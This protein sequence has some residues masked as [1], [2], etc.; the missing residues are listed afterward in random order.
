MKKKITTLFLTLA[1]VVS[2]G[3]FAMISLSDTAVNASADTENGVAT[4][5][6]VSP[7]ELYTFA[8]ATP[9]THNPETTKMSVAGWSSVLGMK[10]F[11]KGG[12]HTYAYIGFDEVDVTNYAFVNIKAM[13]W[14]DGGNTK[15]G[16]YFATDIYT[17]ERIDTGYKTS[18]F[19]S[20]KSNN[21]SVFTPNALY[22]SIPTSLIK[23]AENKLSGLIIKKSSGIGHF[24]VGDIVFSNYCYTRVDEDSSKSTW[25]DNTFAVKM[26]YAVDLDGTDRD[27]QT[28]IANWK[29]EELLYRSSLTVGEAN[30]YEDFT[31]TVKFATPVSAKE[32]D[33]FR[34]KVV[35]WDKKVPY[36]SVTLK[37]LNGTAVTTLDVYYDWSTAGDINCYFLADGLKN[38]S[39]MIEGFILDCPKA[40]NLVFADA[41][42]YKG[43]IE[44]MINMAQSRSGN[45]ALNR[46]TEWTAIPPV[47]S[48]QLY[49]NGSAIENGTVTVAFEL[50]VDSSVYKTLDL[51]AF[52]WN[53]ADLKDVEIRKLDGTLVETIKVKSSY[54]AEGNGDL[55][56]KINSAL[57]ADENGKVGGFKMNVLNNQYGHLLF[58]EITGNVNEKEY[59]AKVVLGDAS[60]HTITY[61]ATDRADKLAEIK[62]LLGVNDAQYTYTN[63]VPEVLPFAE[64]KTY[65]ETR[66]VNEYDVVIGDATAVKVAYGSKLTKPAEDPTKDMTVST[67]YTFDGWYNG[68]TKWNFDNDVV[69]GNVTLVARFN[70]TARQY[71]V[72]IGDN[73]AVKVAYGEKVTKPAD[74]AIT[75]EDGYTITFEGWYNGETKWDFDNDTVTGN[76]TL[77]AKTS[78]K[79]IEYTATVILGD[80]T[81][82]T[83]KYTIESREAKL[84]EIKAM[85]GTNDAQYTYTNDLPEVLPL[86]DK[87]YTETRTVNEYDVVIGDASA[88]KVAYGSKLTKPATDPTK[89]MTASTV[90]TFDGWYN[91][92]VKWDFDKDVVTG[93]VTLTAK[94]TETARK[95]TVTITFTG[96]EKEAV[97]LQVE[98]NGSVDF[99]AYKEDGY[100]MV[101]RNGETEITELTVTGDANITVEYKEAKKSGCNLSVSGLGI[102]M[103]VMLTG[104]VVIVTRGKKQDR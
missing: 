51:K 67:V 93:N 98:Y 55:S 61:T 87:T 53:G 65:T 41:V 33:Y 76:L 1:L 44:P 49:Y 30:V 75:Q 92:S 81:Q 80:N 23:N 69:T 70:E 56:V 74:P 46:Q 60:E 14:T 95:Y 48:E 89:D 36:A 22:V 50:P 24:I 28:Y 63:D 104:A 35:G 57:L 3:A 85:L 52:I 90:Y 31:T 9:D 97:T 5:L 94:F 32:V 100:D 54:Q 102:V 47:A 8:E 82:K 10:K 101:I 73:D 13:F 77:V 18:I 11:V 59:T 91:G 78:K 68:E 43:N 72:V 84:A 4:E 15:L 6:T 42:G 103:L 26:Q 21:C 16:T 62:A 99:N 45:K 7:T 64:G 20:W 79:A 66:T 39:G 37:N 38:E 34:L 17:A 88:V 27:A 58:S 2:V 29:S 83:V 12:D 25:G 19:G 96:L 71:D 86:E 40:T